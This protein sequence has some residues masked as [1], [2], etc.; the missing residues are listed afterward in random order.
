MNDMTTI[1][2]TQRAYSAEAQAFLARKPAL[3]INNEWVSSSHDKMI[4][5]V[6][7]VTRAAKV[8]ALNSCSA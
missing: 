4:E 5:V 7:M 6:D 2:R 8:E 1:D 3:F